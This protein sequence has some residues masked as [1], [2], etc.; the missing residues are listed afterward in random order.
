MLV[1]LAE[2]IVDLLERGDEVHDDDEHDDDDEDDDD[3]DD[4]DVND[5]DDIDDAVFQQS[6]KE[7]SNISQSSS[8]SISRHPT[9][10]SLKTATGPAQDCH[11]PSTSAAQ[12]LVF[13]CCC[14]FLSLLASMIK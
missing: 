8:S 9:P 7:S 6:S 3:D 12:D 1:T 2:M 10:F 5:D 4:D 13:R 11:R 14:R